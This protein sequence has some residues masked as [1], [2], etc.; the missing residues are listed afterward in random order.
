VLG[1]PGAPSSK[2]RGQALFWAGRLAMFSGAW[3]RAATLLSSAAEVAREVGDTVTL[4]LALGKE[5]WLCVETGR[6]AEGLEQVEEAVALARQ[7]GDAWTIAETLNDAGASCDRTDPERG[8]GFMEESLA[9]RR[10]LGDQVNIADSLNN[11]GY[12]QTCLGAYDLAEDALEEGLEIA[13]KLGDLRHLALI[14]GNLGNVSL[15]RED[16]EVAKSR[17]HENLRVSRRIGDKRT[18]LEALRG[19]AAIAGTEGQIETAAALAGTVD[20]LHVSFGGTPS[21]LEV[22]I[23]E[24]FIAPLRR[25]VGDAAWSRL[26][27]PVAEVTIEHTIARALGEQ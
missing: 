12:V 17:Y 27:L 2:S 4:A 7:I 10:A 13:R 22:M 8:L 26:S 16:P 23:D 24:R 1:V 21:R 9:V 14:I 15:F 11:V 25:V 19:L 3:E 5:A 18:S 6:V 20:A